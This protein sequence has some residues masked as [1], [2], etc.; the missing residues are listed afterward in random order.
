MNKITTA[1]QVIDILSPHMWENG[2]EKD[3]GDGTFGI[4][5]ADTIATVA[6]TWASKV[7]ANNIMIANILACGGSAYDAGNR[8]ALNTVIPNQEGFILL[9]A[10][11]P[12]VVEI[13]STT[14]VPNFPFDIWLR[15]T[16]P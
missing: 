5:F 15:Y 2:V 8:I 11:P 14:T 16:K 7:L 3:F 12:L 4:R 1:G 6:N 9:T 10:S 13:Y